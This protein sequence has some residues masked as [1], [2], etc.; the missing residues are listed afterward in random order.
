VIRVLLVLLLTAALPGPVLAAPAKKPA[1]RLPWLPSVPALE[2]P[3]CNQRFTG[4]R[5]DMVENTVIRP[6][7]S[8][9]RPVEWVRSVGY[10][11]TLIDAREAG[12]LTPFDEVVDS[13]LF[14]NR[15]GARRLT[16]V[17]LKKGAFEGLLPRGPWKAVRVMERSVNVVVAEDASGSEWTLIFDH[18]SFPELATGAHMISSRILWAAGYFV[19]PSA[20]VEVDPS[21]FTAAP[22]MV[23]L[24]RYGEPKS[25]IPA[26]P[27]AF[28]KFHREKNGM[29]RAVA[30]LNP[31]GEDCGPFQSKDYRKD[32]PNAY[33]LN[34][35][36]RSMRGLRWFAAWLNYLEANQRNTK[37]WWIPSGDEN[38]GVMINFLEGLEHTLGSNHERSRSARDG[39]GYY[40]NPWSV[41]RQ[42]LTLGF[43]KEDF[44]EAYAPG[45]RG[46][47]YFESLRFR[48]DT[49][50]PYYPHP[51]FQMATELDNYWAGKIL[52]S[53]R[54]RDIEAI[55][56]TAG[57]SSPRTR[58]E[59]VRTLAERRDEITAHVFRQSL[60]VDNF[61]VQPSAGGWDL[62]FTDLAVDRGLVRPSDARC[63]YLMRPKGLLEA[64]ILSLGG[65]FNRFIDCPEPGRLPLTGEIAERIRRYPPV[66][67]TSGPVKWELILSG[68]YEREPSLI[69]AGIP[70][71]EETPGRAMQ[72]IEQIEVPAPEKTIQG[73]SDRAKQ[74]YERTVGDTVRLGS[75]R[76]FAPKLLGTRP[77]PVKL[78]LEYD[79]ATDSLSISGWNR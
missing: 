24:D 45:L 52:S 36:R 69:P 67:L 35:H 64:D 78:E 32:D 12:D 55:V 61:R 47:G 14:M 16:D 43:Y 41:F 30:V 49:W 60:P 75:P 19:R 38:R 62:L 42:L 56:E 20:L 59:M 27:T 2:G 5:T 33:V 9:L 25:R 46:Y 44:E 1:E 66:R 79:P 31:P 4:R 54:T 8:L 58:A 18:P 57:Y 23:W 68:R 22:G 53:F 73:A 71:P 34:E 50:R 7:R 11:T 3:P 21:D 10:R 26:L 70:P 13:S 17:E 65:F 76:E 77:P 29:I 37:T 6:V 72:V 40:L 28:R 15:M 39:H 51:A 63:R 48:P 74:A